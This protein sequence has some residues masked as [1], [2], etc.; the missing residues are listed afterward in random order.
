MLAIAGSA[1]MAFLPTGSFMDEEVI[2]TSSSETIKNV[3]TGKNALSI[4]QDWF[5]GNKVPHLEFVFLSTTR[6]SVTGFY[7]RMAPFPGFM[8]ATEKK[9]E[10]GKHYFSFLLAL[11]HPFS[12]G[13]VH[14]ISSDPA[15]PPSI[16]PRILN[17]KAD[18]S[19]LVEAVKYAR[20]VV[21]TK[22][23][24]TCVQTEVVPGPE[25]QSDLEIEAFV[26]KTIQTVYHPVGTASMLP[27]EAGGVVD[28]H[29]KVYGTTNVRVVGV[30]SVLSRRY[31]L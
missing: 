14:I 1:Y 8:P 3:G 11:L 22:G 29:L 7:L 9:P 23:L 4:Q 16:D 31:M 25:A 13:S 19:L 10:P 18:V 12:R 5:V 6:L 15:V 21:R 17:N 24:D 26:R 20:K 30:L 27:R 28:A 2:K